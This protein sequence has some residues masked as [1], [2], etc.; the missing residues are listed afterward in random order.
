MAAGL[1]DGGGERRH[2]PS[3]AS[4]GSPRTRGEQ[5]VSRLLAEAARAG[6]QVHAVGLDELDILYYLYLDEAIC[7]QVAPT[8]PGW[9]AA[10]PECRKAGWR[11]RWRQRLR[12][13]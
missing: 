4:S 7:Q 11:M 1:R 10:R 12:R 5:A 8:F 9:D 3:R 2:L 13:S 6:I